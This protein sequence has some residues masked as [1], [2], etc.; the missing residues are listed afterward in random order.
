VA[1][2]DKIP[3]AARA[4]QPGW[5]PRVPTSTSNAPARN[6]AAEAYRTESADKATPGFFASCQS[7]PPKAQ[8]NTDARCQVAH[9]IRTL[10]PSKGGAGSEGTSEDWRRCRK[11]S[12]SPSSECTT[13]VTT[14]KTAAVAS[15]GCIVILIIVVTPNAPKQ[16]HIFAF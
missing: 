3:T 6:P 8:P 7:N 10:R 11:I 16:G 1:A 15:N 13:P 12:L 4:T 9:K 14:A 5:R 2:H